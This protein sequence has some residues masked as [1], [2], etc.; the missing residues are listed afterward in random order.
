MRDAARLVLPSSKV[1]EGELKN[2]QRALEHPPKSIDWIRSVLSLITA[3]VL[4]AKA[5]SDLVA[6][7]TDPKKHTDL[8]LTVGLI[9]VA[10]VTVAFIIQELYKRCTEKHPFHEAA[11]AEVKKLIADQENPGPGDAF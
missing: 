11:L 9:V 3:I 2:I 5:Y 6:C 7:V 8:A 10:A 1:T 4:A